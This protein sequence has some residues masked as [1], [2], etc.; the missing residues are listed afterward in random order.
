[1]SETN[2]E[3]KKWAV[4]LVGGKQKLVVEGD[5]IT[6]N[7]IE[8]DVDKTVQVDSMLDKLPVTLK[9]VAHKLGE[10]VTGLKFKNKVRYIRHYG[11]RQQLTELEVVAIGGKAEAPK[12]KTE[13]VKKT[14][15]KVAPKKPAAKK[16]VKKTSEK[17]EA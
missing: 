13:P 8:V 16:V 10:K 14:V 17:K 6:V 2:K 1:M 9:V 4:V 15:E 7:K 11:H 5:H 3:S 12:T